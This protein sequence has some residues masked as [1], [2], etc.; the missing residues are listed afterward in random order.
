MPYRHRGI[1]PLCCCALCCAVCVCLLRCYAIQSRRRRRRRS[2]NVHSAL[3][4]I[5][6]A[7]AAVA[8]SEV[9]ERASVQSTT[10][11]PLYDYEIIVDSQS[12]SECV[13]YGRTKVTRKKERKKAKKQDDEPGRSEVIKGKELVG[14][15]VRA[16]SWS[17]SEAATE[18]TPLCSARPKKHRYQDGPSVGRSTR[19]ICGGG[20]GGGGRIIET[21]SAAPQSSSSSWL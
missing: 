13:R 17:L 4:S 16:W 14:Q 15:R 21:M 3:K 12:A 19:G 5:G 6:V 9:C 2:F 7:A 11:V 1:R 8:N 18:Q 20:G 10:A